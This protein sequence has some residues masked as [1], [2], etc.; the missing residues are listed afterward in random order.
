MI[1]TGHDDEDSI[2]VVVGKITQLVE[3]GEK[4]EIYYNEASDPTLLLD[5]IVEVCEYLQYDTRHITIHFKD[6]IYKD[7]RFT[8]LN[9][10]PSYNIS[11]FSSAIDNISYNGEYD[12]GLFLSRPTS[13]RMEV[14]YKSESLSLKGLTS[15]NYPENRLNISSITEF[16]E[17]HPTTWENYWKRIPY[18]DI[19]SLTND[20]LTPGKNSLGWEDIYKK[21]PMEVVCETNLIPNSLAI[22]E[23]TLRPMYYHR[24][25]L[26]VGPLNYCKNLKDIGF[27]VF[28]DVIDM[29][30]DGLEYQ[31]RVDRVFEIVKD[32]HRKY[33]IESL[34]ERLKPRLQHNH[35]LVVDLAKD[36][37][38]RLQ[39]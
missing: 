18:S 11:V 15:F 24:I 13:V 33:D 37:H 38:E 34:L 31:M 17:D 16:I 21:I 10:V 14:F 1:I 3:K 30:Y 5:A 35:D 27:D 36:H 28:E 29:S 7:D 20:I 39:R 23:K 25:P 26:F 9:D 12:Y 4:V 22:T 2:I 8:V 32:L 6:L 19:D